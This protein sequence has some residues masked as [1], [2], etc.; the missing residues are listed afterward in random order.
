[1]IGVRAGPADADAT[2]GHARP[3]EPDEVA[4]HRPCR[5]GPPR[6]ACWQTVLPVG[7]RT[8]LDQ[9]P[10]AAAGRGRVAPRAAT[11]G[12]AL[13]SDPAALSRLVTLWLQE[14]I[15]QVLTTAW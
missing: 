3:R 4:A 10:G 14:A 6:P 5:A 12:Q 15:D 13:G 8:A 7:R 11:P 9:A 1:M 2:A